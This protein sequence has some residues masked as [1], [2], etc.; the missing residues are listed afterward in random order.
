V[1]PLLAITA[2]T[3]L[4]PQLCSLGESPPRPGGRSDRTA[5]VTDTDAWLMFGGSPNRNMVNTV[6]KG[7]PAAWSIEEGERKH[8]K[9]TAGLGTCA[10]GGPVVAGGKVF[11]GT[12]NERPR[13]PTVKG[14][15]GILMCLR[16]SDGKFLWQIAHDK[17]PHSPFIDW[18]KQ[19]IASTPTVDGQRLYYVTGRSELVCASTEVVPSR[20]RPGV[21]AARVIWRLDMRK[22]LGV[23]PH[24][25]AS[26]SPLVVG[27]T[28]FAVTSNGV[29]E[30]DI[31]LPAPKAPSFIAVNKHT[32][33][34]I[35]TSAAPGLRIMHGQWSNPAYAEVNGTPQVIFPGGDGYLRAFTPDTGK[36]LWKFFCNPRN[37]VYRLGGQGTRSDFIATP[38]VAGNRCYLG[39][40]QDP[41][42]DEGVGHFWCIDLVKATRLGAVN[43][44]NDV[45]PRED[46]FNPAAAVNEWSAL[47]WHFGGEVP[48]ALRRRVGR[49]WYFGRT[50]STAAVQDGL[51][52]AADIDGY[53]Y[54]LDARTGRPY[55]QHRMADATWCSPYWVDG[56]VYIGNDG[57]QVLVFR[58]GEEKKLLAVNDVREPVRSPVVAA[59]GVLY[60]LTSPGR[61]YAI[62][63]R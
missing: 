40:G 7:L 44:D 15:K 37:S 4:L 26:C 27:D 50:L 11:V 53:V 61:L 20:E 29:D 55:W 13:D 63:R 45:S 42:H 22:E 56:K 3:T 25:L 30:G 52:Y 1:A 18:P 49:N 14:D 2:L 33:K 43:K 34:L 57:G 24:C 32:G 41:E 54:C 28:V 39:V 48:P 60:V 17:L 46:N 23:F 9:W 59:G 38:V 8:I 36:L 6:D 21:A 10:W 51:V 58:A 16:E 12:N 31:N 47:G 19:G 35:W 62:A 5:D